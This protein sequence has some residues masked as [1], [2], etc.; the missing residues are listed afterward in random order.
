[1]P[2]NC[3]YTLFPDCNFRAN[4]LAQRNLIGRSPTFMA[5]I[6]LIKKFAAC[7]A[8]VLIEGETGTGKEVAAR[9]IHDLSTRRSA[10]FVPVNCGAL[11]DTLVENELFG[12]MRGAFTDARETQSGLIGRAEGGTLFLDEIESLSPKAQ[13]V[14]L[15][16]L[17]NGTY[18]PLG[19]RAAVA[20]N[21]RVVAASNVDVAQLAKTG[22]FRRDLLYRLTILTV[23]MP[24]LRERPG[25]ERVLAEH[26]VQQFGRRYER[27][28][29]RLD[30][31][32]L[33]Q[34]GGHDWP[35]NVRELEN[36]VHRAFLLTDARSS[37]LS[38]PL[39]QPA[40]RSTPSVFR[41]STAFATPRRRWSSS[42]SASSSSAHSPTAAATSVPLL[43]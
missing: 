42:S 33:E 26:F 3:P 12:H 8:T 22:A 6:A 15:R 39:R 14:L 35:G 17:Q 28:E 10:P 31:L 36:L 41:Q 38:P 21:T 40:P 9:A 29:R 23:R 13:A 7:D 32:S 2:A 11:P 20:A 27:P 43:A 30:S 19:G 37:A 16:F 1:M 18:S 24:A 5:A 25:D 34:L 4:A